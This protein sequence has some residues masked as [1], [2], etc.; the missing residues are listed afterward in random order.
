MPTQ[1][2]SHVDQIFS[3]NPFPNGDETTDN[4]GWLCASGTSSATPMVAAVV[5]LLLEKKSS[6]TADEIKQILMTTPRDI[7]AG[8]SSMGNP[9]GPGWDSATGCGLVNAYEAWRGIP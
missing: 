7:D 1:P 6:L 5:A 4:D 3:G 2:G 8:T 9:A